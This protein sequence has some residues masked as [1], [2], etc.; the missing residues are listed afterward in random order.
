VRAKSTVTA[1]ATDRFGQ[2]VQVKKKVTL[3]P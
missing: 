2:T 3:K 1:T